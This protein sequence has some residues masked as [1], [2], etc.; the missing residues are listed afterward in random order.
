MKK[1]ST[2][3]ISLSKARMSPVVEIPG[4][5]KTNSVKQTRKLK[6]N[7]SH[8]PSSKISHNQNFNSNHNDLMQVNS[9][10]NSNNNFNSNS[11]GMYFPQHMFDYNSDD[12][13]NIRVCVRIRPLSLQE[14]GKDDIKVVEAINN[15]SLKFRNKNAYRSY[16]YNA[17]FDEGS[18]QD[19]IFYSCSVNVS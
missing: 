8:N 18:T 15:T 2:P 12:G 11:N 14:H 17:V 5:A 7:N 4:A 1:K 6:P 13:E 3:Q 9:N 10:S 16:S 19:D